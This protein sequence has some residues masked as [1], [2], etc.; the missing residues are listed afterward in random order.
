MSKQVILD[1]QEHEKIL[2]DVSDYHK[3]KDS[4]QHTIE[5]V[6]NENPWVPYCDSRRIIVP[7]FP[8][9]SP[10]QWITLFQE[11]DEVVKKNEEIRSDIYRETVR[12]KEVLEMEKQFLQ[13]LQNTSQEYRSKMYNFRTSFLSRLCFLFT[14]KLPE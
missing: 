9:D 13:T 1:Y 3:L 5:V 6:F 12:A 8:I 4:F 2:K 14:G 7:R 10:L 11:L